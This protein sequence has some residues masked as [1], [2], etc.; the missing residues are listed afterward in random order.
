MDVRAMVHASLRREASQLGYGSEEIDGRVHVVPGGI[1]VKYEESEFPEAESQVRVSLTLTAHLG[2]DQEDTATN[3]VLD[4]LDGAGNTQQEAIDFAVNMWMVGVLPAL[5]ALCGQ[6]PPKGSEYKT[7][8]LKHNLAN[9][10]VD[11]DVFLGP[12]QFSSDSSFA[13]QQRIEQLK[14]VDHV[15]ERILPMLDPHRPHWIR[16]YHCRREEGLMASNCQVDNRDFAEGRGTLFEF[17]WPNVTSEQW[18][19][20]FLTVIPH[21]ALVQP[22]QA[23]AAV[24][25]EEEKTWW[26]KLIEL[27]NQDLLK[28]S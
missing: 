27:G 2:E 6:K 28:R 5:C 14:P 15:L 4:R 11:W 3:T 12:L 19:R 9:A 17:T 13:L 25:V 24:V 16:I 1:S 8:N 21:Y 22:L 26:K 10:V 18:F 20:Q 7:S 23:K